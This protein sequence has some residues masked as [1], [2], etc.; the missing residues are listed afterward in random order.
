[1]ANSKKIF[2]FSSYVSKLLNQ[3]EHSAP[4]I[5]NEER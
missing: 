4:Q 2:L 1:M 3:L 5:K